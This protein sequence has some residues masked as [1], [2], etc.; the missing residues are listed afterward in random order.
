MNILVTGGR[1]VLGVPLTKELRRRGHDVWSIDLMHSN[2]F[3]H[4]RVD[5]GEYRQLEQYFMDSKGFE[6]V[7]HTAGEF[8]RNNGELM[9]ESAWRTNTVG[10][11]NMLALQRDFGYRMVFFSSSE[12]YGDYTGV[13]SE[14][15]PMQYPI[16]QLN[17]YAISKW[18]SEMQILN[19]SERYDLENIRVR[20]FNTYGPGEF[21]TPYR[22][23]IARFVYSALHN[24]PYTVHL[25]HK[26]SFSYIMDTVNTLSNISEHFH[27]GECYN[28]GSTTQ[29]P[30]EEISEIILHSVGIDD[31]MVT[32]SGKEALTTTE[33]NVD[34]SKAIKDLGHE[35]TMDIETG[36][37]KTVE[38]M[39]Q[40]YDK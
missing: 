3:L 25:G 24:M 17:D 26:R 15:V 5:V 32:Y 21:Y 36:I 37:E 27:P 34:I 13:M 30:I 28:I 1:G 35:L 31:S 29:Y 14:D 19:D 22:S 23:V 39:R 4:N 33:K 11:K 10:T 6:F 20:L 38:W 16:R 18:A 7:Y 9:Y 40:V 12:I 8:G 2:E